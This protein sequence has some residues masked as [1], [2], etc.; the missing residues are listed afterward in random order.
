[1]GSCLPGCSHY[2]RHHKTVWKKNHVPPFYIWN[3]RGVRHP[4]INSTN[5]SG[6]PNFEIWPS[7][8]H[9]NKHIGHYIVYLLKGAGYHIQI[10]IMYL[11]IYLRDHPFQT[12]YMNMVAIFVNEKTANIYIRVV[13]GFI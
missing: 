3:T 10:H 11:Y 12:N 5:I 6:D 7:T 13:R 8:F 9:N 2:R 4:Y 1:M